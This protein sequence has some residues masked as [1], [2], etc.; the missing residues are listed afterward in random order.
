MCHL[1][2]AQTFQLW[3]RF[4]EVKNIF[5]SWSWGHFF[6]HL[7]W[8]FGIV[9]SWWHELCEHPCLDGRCCTSFPMEQL[10]LALVREGLAEAL[11]ARVPG[12]LSL[13]YS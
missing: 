4:P 5:G 2:R 7:Q 11:G 8:L 1:L 6:G 3:V 10:P 13:L 9:L 12:F